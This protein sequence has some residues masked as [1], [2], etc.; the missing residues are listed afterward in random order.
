MN[1]MLEKIGTMNRRD[2]LKIVD[3]VTNRLVRLWRAEQ[4]KERKRP[5]RQ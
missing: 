3:A 4:A 5:K 2:A 1:E